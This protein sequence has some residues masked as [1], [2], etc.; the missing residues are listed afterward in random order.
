MSGRDQWQLPRKMAA[1]SSQQCIGRKAH[2]SQV[3]VQASQVY[4]YASQVDTHTQALAFPNTSANTRIR[5]KY[6]I[7][8]I[9]ILLSLIF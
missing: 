6:I 7:C 8:F 1:D 5:I 2:A 9:S 3:D 4:A